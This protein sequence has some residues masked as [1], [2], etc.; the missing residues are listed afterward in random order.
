MKRILNL[1]QHNATHEQA[2]AGVVDLNPVRRKEIQELLT[3]KELPDVETVSRVAGTIATRM[4]EW[5][6]NIHMAMIGGAP[7][8][9]SALEDALVCYRVTP[10]YAFSER[11][12]EEE[13][14][15]DGSVVK[16]MVFRHLG[17]VGVDV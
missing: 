7:Y 15:P 12:S 1:T 11:E 6:P 17:F 16:R 10:V 9:M 13:E 14:M 8:L 4:N 5:E 2:M 3:F